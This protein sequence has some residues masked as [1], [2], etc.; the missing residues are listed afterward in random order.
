[1][2]VVVPFRGSPEELAELRASLARLRLEP[3]DSLLVVDNS[4]DGRSLDA[5]VSVL[6]APA[7]P[8][9]GYARNRGA[10]AGKAEWLLF[11]D[12]DVVPPPDLIER[13]FDPVPAEG[14]G[15]MAGGVRDEEVEGPAAARYAYLR[16]SM[17]QDHTFSFGRWGF[18]QTANAA[19]RRAAFEAVGGFR[20]DIR[21]AEDA[22][23][24]YRLKAAG[25]QVER[26]E[27]AAVVHRSRQS[28]RSFVVQKAIHGAG[29]AWLAD[30]YP[31][32]F[33]GHRRPGL[34]FWALRHASSRLLA[35][36]RARDRDQALWAVFE[37]LDIV[38]RE[39]GRSL[40]N[41]R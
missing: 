1:M 26:R 24:N 39:F 31:G 21:A 4:R 14:T 6:H 33:P 17:S 28:I 9:P 5:P 23:L 13:Y 10:A 40:P 20:E 19:V 30:A 37:P 32:S 11:L 36:A 18:A 15:L 2:D 8:T 38:T 41:R 12:A 27:H 29:A 16:R 3:A 22:D 34:V 7:S 35:A 25:W